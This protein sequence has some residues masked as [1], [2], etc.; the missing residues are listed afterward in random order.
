MTAFSQLSSNQNFKRVVLLLW[1]GA[2]AFWFAFAALPTLNNYPILTDDEARVMLGAHTLATTGRL[3]SDIFQG[4]WNTDTSFFLSLP[5]QRILIAGAFLVGGESIVTARV[6]S[7]ISALVVLWCVGILTARWYGMGAMFLATLL[8]VFWRSFIGSDVLGLPLFGAARSARYD[9]TAVAFIW[10]ALGTFTIYLQK[11]TR[12]RA[13]VTG[14]F[15]GIA[16]LTQFFGGLVIPVLVCALWF[17]YRRTMF[18][19]AGTWWMLAG[20]ALVLVPFAFYIASDYNAFVTQTFVFK[21]PRTRFT[22]LFFYVENFQNEWTR[23]ADIARRAW[24]DSPSITAQLAALFTLVGIVA[25]LLNLARR[26]IQ[27]REPR[28][29]LLALTLL[30]FPLGLALL[31]STKAP[32]YAIAFYPL[33][34]IALGVLWQDI[35]RAR[36]TLWYRASVLAISGII[37]AALLFKY[38][39]AFSLDRFN[40]AGAGNYQATAARITTLVPNDAKLI[41]SARIG[42][43]LRAFRPTTTTSVAVRWRFASDNERDLE[44]WLN[45]FE[46]EYFVLDEAAFVDFASDDKLNQQFWR[47]LKNC[48]E[49]QTTFPST[50]YGEIQIYRLGW[51]APACEK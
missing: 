16:T 32:L 22:E 7:V 14:I 35:F 50:F 34:C 44:K 2:L 27:K 6:V 29:F 51:N 38:A 5:V 24:L 11:Q 28:P 17:A 15:A 1:L 9:M 37:L 18:R 19:Q 26:L 36:N 47:V 43:G 48:T 41:S 10:L 49:T 39:G 8:L 23:Y 30:I 12:T 21:A 13:I 31:E 20:C 42:W 25:A 3:G 45:D 4:A 46:I 33:L 40:A